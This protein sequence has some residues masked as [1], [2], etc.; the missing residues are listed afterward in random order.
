MVTYEIAAHLDERLWPSYEAYM[1]DRHIPD[2]LAT[3]CFHSASFARGAPG[4]YLI[5]YQAPDRSSLDR[6]LAEHAEQLRAHFAA[7]FPDGVEL[8]RRVWDELEIWP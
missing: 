5:R 6:Y 1:R 2:L 7:H 8:S 4:D 3:G